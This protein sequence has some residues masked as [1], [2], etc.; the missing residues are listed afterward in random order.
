MT[1]VHERTQLLPVARLQ[2][3]RA[4]QAQTIHLIKQGIEVC[5]Y[6]TAPLPHAGN[7][8]TRSPLFVSPGNQQRRLCIQLDCSDLETS[9]IAE[10][11]GARIGRERIVHPGR[12]SMSQFLAC[13][14]NRVHSL[15]VETEVKALVDRACDSDRDRRR[16]TQP[17]AK[18]QA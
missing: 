13:E 9:V 2:Q 17:L 1:H 15:V 11:H 5:R 3:V 12:R 4:L 18:R 7:L 16:R 8:L 6:L 14:R 10:Q